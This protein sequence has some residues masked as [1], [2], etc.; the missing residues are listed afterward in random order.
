[1]AESLSPTLIALRAALAFHEDHEDMQRI[2]PTSAS[3]LGL[4]GSVSETVRLVVE[5]AYAM[6]PTTSAERVA[7]I[8]LVLGYEG[9]FLDDALVVALNS[10]K[11]GSKPLTPVVLVAA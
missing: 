3:E 5:S 4:P 1:M 6:T 7:M 10:I 2:C 11:R 9:R 8:D